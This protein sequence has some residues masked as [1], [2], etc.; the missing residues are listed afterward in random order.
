MNHVFALIDEDGDFLD[1]AFY[2]EDN[3]HSIAVD[4]KNDAVR[5][6][7]ELDI[8]VHLIDSRNLPHFVE[9]I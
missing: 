8:K 3:A 2:D 6:G 4:F 7:I 5:S 9:I 1:Y